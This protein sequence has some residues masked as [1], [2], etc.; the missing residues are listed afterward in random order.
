MKR[1]IAGLLTGAMLT[2]GMPVFAAGTIKLIVNGKEVIPNV[3]PQIINGTVMVPVRFVSEALGAK[4]EWDS[5]RNAVI[6][7]SQQPAIAPA[8]QPSVVSENKAQVW[9]KIEKT[10]S[11]I[12][13]MLNVI[14]NPSKSE[15][16]TVMTALYDRYQEIQTW[17]T[18]NYATLRT[19]YLEA[20]DHARLVVFYEQNQDKVKATQ[21]LGA[22]KTTYQY[23]NLEVQKL[24]ALGL[25]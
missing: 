23:I 3:P 16:S 5:T 7:T 18:I 10:N 14:G 13:Q 6:I 24:K 15:L 21:S 9:I 4:V 8:Q 20:I 11:T 2:L 1:F 12:Q 19:L 25:L 17:N 22:L